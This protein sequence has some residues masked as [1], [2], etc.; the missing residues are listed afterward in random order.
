MHRTAPECLCAETGL[1]RAC[2]LLEPVVLAG[3]GERLCTAPHIITCVLRRDSV[4]RV[5]LVRSACC[6]N[7]TRRGLQ[8]ALSYTLHTLAA[9]F[10]FSFFFLLKVREC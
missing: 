8:S 3:C 9:F 6:V 1:C 2:H 5:T 7:Q 10:S 4:E